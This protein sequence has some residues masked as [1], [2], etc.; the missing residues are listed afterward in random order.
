MNRPNAHQWRRITGR[1][2][3]NAPIARGRQLVAKQVGQLTPALANETSDDHIGARPTRDL[4]EQGRLAHARR[5]KQPD[6]LP[7]PNPSPRFRNNFYAML[8]AEKT[9]AVS[10]F[11][12]RRQTH[13]SRLTLLRWILSPLAAC[14]L[15]VLG[16]IA[17]TRYAPPAPAPATTT[18]ATDPATARELAELRQRVDSMGQLVGC[19]AGTGF[20]AAIISSLHD[21]GFVFHVPPVGLVAVLI[22]G[23]IAGIVAAALPARRAARMDVL[24]AITHD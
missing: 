18:P 19:I 17:G 1:T 7:T 11:A 21:Q 22:V 16:F 5:G 4:T 14:G 8:E 12:A 20:A 15:L 2:N 23:I 6:A 9:S 24:R 10:V 3:D 13:A